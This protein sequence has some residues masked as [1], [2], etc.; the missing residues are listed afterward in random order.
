MRVATRMGS[1]CLL[2]HHVFVSDKPLSEDPDV[3]RK[4]ADVWTYHIAGVA[5]TPTKISVKKPGRYVQI[6]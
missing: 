2:C 3:N 6:Q 1:H 5:G 4:R